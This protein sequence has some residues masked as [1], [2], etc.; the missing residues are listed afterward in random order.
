M[1]ISPAIAVDPVSPAVFGGA[2]VQE[3]YRIRLDRGDLLLESIN[4]AIKQYGIEDGL[5]LTAVGSLEE[6]TYHAASTLAP[7]AQDKY[8]TVK[9]PMELL[10]L[11]GIIAAGEPHLHMT[12]STIKRG[13]FGGHLENGCKVL[14]RVELTIAKTSGPSLERKLNRDQTPALQVK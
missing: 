12:M 3:I 7:V 4:A 9:G 8:F 6:C 14:Y 2:Q 10:N 1:W 11:N 13:A 5:V